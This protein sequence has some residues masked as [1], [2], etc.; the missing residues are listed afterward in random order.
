[1]PESAVAIDQR[2]PYLWLVDEDRRVARRPIEIGLRERGVVE[3]IQGLTAGSEV[4]TA[5][6]HK[7]SEGMRVKIAESPLAG[8]VRQTPPEGAILGEGT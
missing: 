3:V 1:M 5:G 8:R 6:T 4:V 7:V 2:G